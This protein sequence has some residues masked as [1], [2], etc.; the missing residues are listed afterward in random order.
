MAH[1]SSMAHAAENLPDE[2]TSTGSGIKLNRQFLQ[3]RPDPTGPQQGLFWV[4]LEIW[5]L[6]GLDGG[7]D[8]DR[9]CDPLLVAFVRR[10]CG[11][12][13]IAGADVRVG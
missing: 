12:C 4:G 3:L 10:K 2:T 7:R 8:R 13:Q 6:V 5:G 9:T 11:R 1:F